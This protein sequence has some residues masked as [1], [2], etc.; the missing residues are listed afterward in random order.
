MINYILTNVDNNRE[1]PIHEILV[2]N[3]TIINKYVQYI[4]I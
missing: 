2:Y 4:S 1:R 3:D